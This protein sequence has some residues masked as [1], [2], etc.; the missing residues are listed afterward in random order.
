MDLLKIGAQ[1]L[2][3]RLGNSEGVTE[4]GIMSALGKLLPTDAG[5]D[6]D[7]SALI[8]Q[9]SGNGL[10]G[11]ASSF[12]SDGDNSS[13]SISQIMSIFGESKVDQFAN[14]INVDKTQAAEGLAGMLPD[15]IDMQSK[16]GS[17]LGSL[18][19]IGKLFS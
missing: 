1:L 4:G 17:L 16:G 11:L 9:F 15:L 18:G 3:N 13:I 8:S 2:M 10:A 7:L 6:I 12:L 14:D 5:G 19:S